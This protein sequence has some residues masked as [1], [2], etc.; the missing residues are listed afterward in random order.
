MTKPGILIVEDNSLVGRSLR[1]M[2]EQ[3][4]YEPTL[5]VNGQAARAYLAEHSPAFIILDLLLPDASGQEL[6]KLWRASHP[7]VPI[8]V[9]SAYGDVPVAVECLKA[10]AYD[11]LTKPI[12]KVMLLKALD[13]AMQR[14]VLSRQVS[15]LTRLTQREFGTEGGENIVTES[16]AMCQVLQMAKLIGQSAFSCVLIT[17]ESGVGKSMLARY[18]H[19]AS[20]RAS[21]PFIEV[22]C[23]GIPPS[24]IES[25]L[26]GHRKGAFTDA[27][28][29]RIGLFETADHGTVFLDEIGDMDSGLQ[30]KLLRVIE[31]KR[32]RRIGSSSE[33]EVDVAI[34]AATNQNVQ[35]LIGA[36]SFRSDLYYRLNVIPLVVPPLR[37]RR[38]DILP[39]AEMFRRRFARRF[40]KDITGF[41][42]EARAQML[43]Y[44][45]PGNCR[46]LR[47]VVERGCLLTQD[48]E[49]AAR[50]LMI[51]VDEVAE[52]AVAYQALSPKAL[53]DVERGAI[54]EALRAARGNKSRAAEILGVHRSTLYKKLEV[55]GL[56]PTSFCPPPAS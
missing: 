44:D 55:M 35:R 1:Q 24:L 16:Q 33:I 41:D 37:E 14:S 3:E 56:D 43:A 29:E 18:L 48:A 53:R 12:E 19:C 7:D 6:L 20:R 51:P 2:L 5:A 38:E 42:A 9:V 11:F 10:G 25:E 13:N 36:G 26:F 21:G 49:I 40:G 28:E 32:F 46:E 50:L 22:D 23:A 4:G 17:G 39:L 15:A 8:I 31:T 52:A 27:R 47:N 34:V 54:V 45:W 30:A